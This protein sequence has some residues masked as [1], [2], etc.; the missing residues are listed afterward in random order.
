[1][2]SKDSV[3][4]TDLQIDLASSDPYSTLNGGRLY[5]RAPVYI[6][7]VKPERLDLYQRRMWELELRKGS[8]PAEP[9]WENTYY[10]THEVFDA[11]RID[12]VRFI[13]LGQCRNDVFG[14][15]LMKEEGTSKTYRRIGLLICLSRERRIEAN[16]EEIIIV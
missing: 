14:I 11:T 10:T 4:T 13:L 8:T 1:M 15:M 12:E 5:I 7:S 2:K 9:D 16:M 3:T 6:V